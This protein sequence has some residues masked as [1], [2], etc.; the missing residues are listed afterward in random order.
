M[1]F[2][3]IGSI[4]SIDVATQATPSSRGDFVSDFA[5]MIRGNIGETNGLLNKADKISTDFSINKTAD[6]HEVMIA[7]EEAGM[8]LNYT[9]QVRNK[10]IEGYQELMR[11]QI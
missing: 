6:L 8:A 3:S 2:S 7:V 4:G 1:A 11:M 5:Q 9:M 10:V